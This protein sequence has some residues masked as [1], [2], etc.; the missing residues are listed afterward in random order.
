MDNHDDTGLLPWI[1]SAAI[2][3]IMGIA[4]ATYSDESDAAGSQSTRPQ[5]SATTIQSDSV[6]YNPTRSAGLAQW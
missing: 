2:M 3:L 6:G 1:L 5:S 4:V